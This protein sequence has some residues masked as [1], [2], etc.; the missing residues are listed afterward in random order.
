MKYNNLKD[1]FEEPNNIW[2]KK[3][4][5]EYIEIGES[6]ITFKIQDGPIKEYG[7]NGCQIDDIGIVWLTILM[8]FNSKFGSRFNSLAITRIQSALNWQYNR[9][10]ERRQ[11]KVEGYDKK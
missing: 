2:V 6:T 5:M 4:D 10:E 8:Y 3:L 7:K 11:R 9:K 1:I